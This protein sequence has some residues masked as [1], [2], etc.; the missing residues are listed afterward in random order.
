MQKELVSGIEKFIGDC[1][2]PEVIRNIQVMLSRIIA[3]PVAMLFLVKKV[4]TVIWMGPD[5]STQRSFYSTLRCQPI[6]EERIRK[7]KELDEKYVQNDDLLDFF[8]DYGERP[9]L[10]NELYEE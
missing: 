5:N 7:R 2:E 9:E 4:T 10:W 8:I 3:K 6:I 1:K